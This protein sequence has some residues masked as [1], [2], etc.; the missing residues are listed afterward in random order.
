MSKLQVPPQQPLQKSDK[1]N[2]L[3]ILGRE[4][5]LSLAEI[6]AFFL[7]NNINFNIVYNKEN[8]L[9]LSTNQKIDL[10][11]LMKSL[12]GT[13]KICEVAEHA[14]TQKDELAKFLNTYIP[15]GK[16]EF[17]INGFNALGIETKKVLK[18]MNRSARYIEAKNTA[19]VI[20]NNLVKGGADI[21][22]CHN[23]VFI[24][25]A[26]QPIDDF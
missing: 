2:L 13:I 15:T 4:T 7:L 22:I 1:G 8:K 23:Q 21:E 24:T 6:K 11:E 25:K 12:G 3:F 14:Q 16:I 5:L 18:Q 20:Y 19:T 10:P 26:I 17:S 9:I